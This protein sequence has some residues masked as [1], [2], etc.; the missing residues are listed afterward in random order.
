MSSLELHSFARYTD[1]SNALFAD[2]EP[3]TATRILE[4]NNRLAACVANIIVV[5]RS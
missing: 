4:N 2:S 5:G 3:S 1:F